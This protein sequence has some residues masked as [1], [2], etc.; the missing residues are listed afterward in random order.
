MIDELWGE[1]PPESAANVLHTYISHLRRTLEPGRRRGVDGL[2]VT[3]PPGYLLR[4]EPGQ[5]DLHRFEEL[6]REARS[7][8]N[9]AQALM[10]LNEALALWRGPPLQELAF[11]RFRKREISRI[12]ELHLAAVERRIELEL[13]L[14]RDGDRVAG[15]RG[16]CRGSIR[17]ASGCWDS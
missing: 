16:A 1:R 8:G 2:I 15:A 17:Y 10:T 13:A 14:G 5:L 7:S 6:V 12:E 11:D 4:L 9:Q 3:R